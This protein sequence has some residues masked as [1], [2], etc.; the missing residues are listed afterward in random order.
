VPSGQKPIEIGMGAKTVKWMLGPPV[1]VSN[2]GTGETWRYS[3][4]AWVEFTASGY[5]YKA[6]G[7]DAESPKSNQEASSSDIDKLTQ[8]I[9]LLEAKVADLTAQIE[10]RSPAANTTISADNQSTTDSGNNTPTAEQWR[11]IRGG[12]T[13]DWV[14]KT[15]GK[16]M[17]ITNNGNG[18]IWKYSGG[19]WV[20]F[21]DFGT[22]YKYGGYSF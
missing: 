21:F 15:L 4:G 5:V 6:G 3:N 17:R 20:E 2:D 14:L 13:M 9:V 11:R 8:R 7:F 19:G 22:V 10:K 1:Q 16:P 18:E 12:Q